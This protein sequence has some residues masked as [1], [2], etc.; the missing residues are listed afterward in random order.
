M[1][2]A[3]SLIFTV[4]A[5]FFL[6]QSCKTVQVNPEQYEETKIYFGSGGG[7]T[8]QLNEFCM[9]S[10]GE[11]YNINPASREATLRNT[12]SKSETKSLFKKIEKAN[13]SQYPYDKPGNMFFWMRHH[14]PADT[15]YLIWGSHDIKTDT[16]VL[17]IYKNLVAM[18][19][20][21]KK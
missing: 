10:N 9:L 15:T 2:L 7:F 4:F 13:L 20:Q 11:I 14:T 1:N 8:G 16:K 19:K 21:A 6:F 17:N 12:V 3:F 18:S 5:A